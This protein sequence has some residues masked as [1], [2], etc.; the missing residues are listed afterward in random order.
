MRKLYKTA[1]ACGLVGVGA[2]GLQT[3]VKAEYVQGSPFLTEISEDARKIG[4]E[5]GVY[6]SVMMAQA[7]LESG[8]GTSGLANGYNNLMGIKGAYKDGGTVNLPTQEE[9]E[10]GELYTIDDYF[11]AYPDWYSSLED[12]ADLLLTNPRYYPA[13]KSTAPD[14]IS[15]AWEL[16]GVYATDSGYADK[17]ID[18]I[19]R[20]DL[21]RF[22]RPLPKEEKKE[23]KAKEEKAKEEKSK[24]DEKAKNKV[25]RKSLKQGLISKLTDNK[26]MGALLNALLSYFETPLD[27]SEALVNKENKQ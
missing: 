9:D 5:K 2:Y 11:R 4:Q 12:Y 24:K 8:N 6:A 23:D 1:L 14:A 16:N 27:M 19:E 13:L 26:E 17:I 25:D 18:I 20:Y 22:D 7:F 3:E 15:A 10:N 21:T